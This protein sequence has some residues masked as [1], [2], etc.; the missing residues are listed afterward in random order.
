M[1]NK[2]ADRNT[3]FIRKLVVPALIGIFPEEQKSPQNLTI[4]LDMR[5]DFR[6]AA[7]DDDLRKT[8]DYAEVR[9]AVIDFIAE[10]TFNLVETCADRLATFLLERFKLNSICLSI[11]KR[12]FD[13]TDAE[14]VGVVVER[15]A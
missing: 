3:I 6:E 5:V 8:I 12:P 11:T 7:R 13:I 1:K 14:G 9:R 4:D 15:S 2:L 10:S